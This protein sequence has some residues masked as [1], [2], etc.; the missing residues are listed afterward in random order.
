MPRL[1]EERL[2]LA[3]RQ[4]VALLEPPI[5][6][7]EPLDLVVRDVQPAVQVLDRERFA[8]GAQIAIVED[9]AMEGASFRLLQQQAEHS[10]VELPAVDEK[11]SLYV[12]LQHP[13]DVLGVD[14]LADGL[15]GV[16]HLDAPAL[17]GARAGLDEPDPLASLLGDPGEAHL[18]SL[19]LGVRGAG[20]NDEA[21]RHHP[22]GVQAAGREV[23]RQC[24]A[25]VALP[26]Q[27]VVAIE[28]VVRSDGRRLWDRCE[29]ER[30]G[31]VAQDVHARSALHG[32][33]ELLVPVRRPQQVH[34][35]LVASGRC[36]RNDAMAKRGRLRAGAQ[37]VAGGRPPE[38]SLPEKATDDPRV[39]AALHHEAKLRRAATSAAAR[40]LRILLLLRRQ[41]IK[42]PLGLAPHQRPDARQ[43][44]GAVS[45]RP[46]A[47]GVAQ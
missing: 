5:L 38:A 34:L 9:V 3:D 6:I 15:L 8:G 23:P 45:S 7:A 12:L 43:I 40:K 11:R 29:L 10:D 31:L 16:E 46:R 17:V 27:H 37:R 25:Q 36:E 41:G 20:A 14:H 26:A 24:L 1:G 39:V 2:E 30:P 21:R 44:L 32:I 22:E 42:L 47:H 4:L 28:V 19:V 35:E 18:P 33:Q 13:W